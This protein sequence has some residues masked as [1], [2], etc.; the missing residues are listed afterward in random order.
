MA[1]TSDVWQSWQL[2][3]ARVE[4]ASHV[5]ELRQSMTTPTA[6]TPGA[7]SEWLQLRPSH[8]PHEAFGRHFE[9]VSRQHGARIESLTWAPS[10]GGRAELERHTMSATLR[11]TYSQVLQVVASMLDDHPSKLTLIR[12]GLRRLVPSTDVEA[13]VEWAVWIRSPVTPMQNIVR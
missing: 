11:G 13:Q 3:L 7:W 12:L 1:G 2:D 4:L 10:Q 5:R 9:R 6:Q 8:L